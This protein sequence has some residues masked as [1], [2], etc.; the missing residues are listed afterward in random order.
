MP[1]VRVR[2]RVRVGAVP[3]LRARGGE[4]PRRRRDLVARGVREAHVERRSLVRVSVRVRVRVR[5]RVDV[6][7]RSLVRVRARSRL[8]L[9]V[10][11]RVRVRVRARV[12]A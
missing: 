4:M 11:V 9:R 12:R 8:R 10:T 2:A 5:V 3:N 6:E 7:R 1:R